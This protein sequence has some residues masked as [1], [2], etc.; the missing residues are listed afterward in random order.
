MPRA[1]SPATAEQIVAVVEAVVANGK[2]ST[3]EFVAEFGDL[4]DV[5]A[6]NAL[7]LAV[8]L[9]FLKKSGSNYSIDSQVCKLLRSPNDEEKAAILRVMLES[10]D[11]FLVFREQIEATESAQTAARQTKTLLDID[12]HREEI[13]DTLLSLATFS[14]ALIPAS[15]GKYERDSKAISNLLHELAVACADL[16]A[17][18][19]RVREEIGPDASN[20]VSHKNVITPLA[21]GLRFAAAGDGR[22]AVVNAGNAIDTFLDEFAGRAGVSLAGATGI[23]GKLD[24]LQQTNALPRKLVFKGKYL[25]HIRNAADHGNDSDI[26]DAWAIH[27]GTGRAYVFV[28]CSFIFSVVAKENNRHEI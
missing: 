15:G 19:H 6:T 28:A 14:G 4:T 10:Y 22:E 20:V 2:A 27:E 5:Q 12:A 17:A 23:N 7:T 24:K 25:G 18:I 8:D 11:P 16:S 13:K 9:G 3:S 1:F 21:A 26:N